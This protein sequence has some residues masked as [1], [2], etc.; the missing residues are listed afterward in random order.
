MRS[1]SQGQVGW[2]QPGQRQRRT[3][4]VG[5]ATPSAHCVPPLLIVFTIFTSF[6]VMPVPREQL[7]Q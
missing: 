6:I 3:R 1:E 2:S 5:L 7:R 4:I